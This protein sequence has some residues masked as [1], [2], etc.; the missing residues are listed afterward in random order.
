[1]GFIYQSKYLYQVSE[2]I[3]TVYLKISINTPSGVHFVM[4]GSTDSSHMPVNT[5]RLWTYKY[6]LRTRPTKLTSH[7]SAYLWSHKNVAKKFACGVLCGDH[8]Y[9]REENPCACPTTSTFWP[10]RSIDA[11]IYGLLCPCLS[12]LGSFHVKSPGSH[13]TRLRCFRKK[14]LKN[15]SMCSKDKNKIL[16]ANHY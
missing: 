6:E 5:H 11:P 16:D 1:M 14:L 12:T 9:A 10:V 3:L 4:S 13:M 2:W 15:T 7:K 8:R